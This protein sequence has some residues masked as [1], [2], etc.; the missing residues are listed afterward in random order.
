MPRER[1]VSGIYVAGEEQTALAHLR[2]GR[3]VIF[4]LPHSGNIDLATAWIMT[5]GAGPVS[6]VAEPRHLPRSLSRKRRPGG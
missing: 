4:A 5:R 3:G 1:I 6:T 2:A